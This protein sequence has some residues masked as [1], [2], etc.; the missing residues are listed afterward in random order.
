MAEVLGQI[1]FRDDLK[2]NLFRK[3]SKKIYVNDS[4]LKKTER[5]KKL[6]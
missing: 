1:D 3:G 6:Y 4:I 2:L 5:N